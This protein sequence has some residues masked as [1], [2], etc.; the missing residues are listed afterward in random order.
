MLDRHQLHECSYIISVSVCCLRHCH[1]VQHRKSRDVW[2]LSV[3]YQKIRHQHEHTRNAKKYAEILARLVIYFVRWVSVKIR[4]NGSLL[5]ILFLSLSLYLTHTRAH[6]PYDSTQATQ[7]NKQTN[8]SISSN[9]QKK[10]HTT[11]WTQTRRRWDRE[12]RFV[13]LHTQAQLYL[14]WICI[15]LGT[16]KKRK[17]GK[18]WKTNLQ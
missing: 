12:N 15:A 6:T 9:G 4:S 16:D 18:K 2:V 13:F 14:K 5:L 8:S 1:T 10:K 11:I 3:W 17:R 7:L